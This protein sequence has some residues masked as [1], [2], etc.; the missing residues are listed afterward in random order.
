MGHFS[1]LLTLSFWQSCGHIQLS[2]QQIKAFCWYIG[3]VYHLICITSY[4]HSLPEVQ[5]SASVD[6]LTWSQKISDLPM[7]FRGCSWSLVNLFSNF[8]SSS[9]FYHI[10]LLQDTFSLIYVNL[11][12]YSYLALEYSQTHTRVKTPAKK[13]KNPMVKQA[14]NL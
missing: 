6:T 14:F 7:A 12:D 2:S 9:S 8:F 10:F 3:T 13:V 1:T 11:W 5:V 4:P